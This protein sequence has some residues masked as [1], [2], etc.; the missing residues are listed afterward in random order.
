[1]GNESKKFSFKRNDTTKVLEIFTEGV[2][3][4]EDGAEYVKSYKAEVA[5]I[6]PGEYTLKFDCSNL[7]LN[8]PEVLPILQGC[9]EMYKVNNFKKIIA[10]V[11]NSK[12]SV[13][14]KMQIGRLARTV[15]LDN[16]EII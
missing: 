4:P 9:F 14:L 11:G 2:F 6:T 13:I 12:N 7:E 3:T 1:M 16:I 8:R 15:G 5:K 10:T